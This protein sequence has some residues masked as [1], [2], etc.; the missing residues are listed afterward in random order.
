MVFKVEVEVCPRCGCEMRIVGFVTEHAV[1]TRILAHLERRGYDARAGVAAVRAARSGGCR[2]MT[3][4][5]AAAGGG[6][7]PGAPRADGRAPAGRGRW[8]DAGWENA[9]G[10]RPGRR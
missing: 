3:Y 2:A 7:P 1:I 10:Q 8:E 5:R 4:G 9:L 6:A